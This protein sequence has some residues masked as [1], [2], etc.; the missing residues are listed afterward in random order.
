MLYGDR[1]NGVREVGTLLSWKFVGYSILM[2]T[3]YTTSDWLAKRQR[4]R[5]AAV[6]ECTVVT[7]KMVQ[8]VV[9]KIYENL[10]NYAFMHAILHNY[11]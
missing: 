9:C 6:T 8:I 11:V 4:H 7:G 1:R 10:H 3:Y 2:V 5:K